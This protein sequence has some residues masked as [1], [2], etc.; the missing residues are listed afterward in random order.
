MVGKITQKLDS[1]SKQHYI[2]KGKIEELL[3]LKETL[4][5]EGIIVD[6]ELTPTQAQNYE[7]LLETKVGRPYRL[8]FGHFCPQGAYPRR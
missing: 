8:D 7:E 3:R 1:P 4:N 2:G 6:D 5:Y